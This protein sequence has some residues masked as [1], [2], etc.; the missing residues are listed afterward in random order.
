MNKNFKIIFTLYSL[1]LYQ[2]IRDFYLGFITLEQPLLLHSL[3]GFSY[4][5]DLH[6]CHYCIIFF[7]SSSKVVSTIIATIA[8]CFSFLFLC[9]VFHSF[10][11]ST[12]GTKSNRTIL[13]IKLKICRLFRWS[14][15]KKLRSKES[16][17]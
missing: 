9:Y 8:M 7:P 15:M 11:L 6:H 12:S 1:T 5:F 4:Y 3:S 14:A 16:L 13:P 17:V 2:S 10:T